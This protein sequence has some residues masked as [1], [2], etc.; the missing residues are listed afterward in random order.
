MKIT[1]E[2]LKKIIVKESKLCEQVYEIEKLVGERLYDAILEGINSSVLSFTK[3]DEPLEE[4]VSDYIYGEETRALDSLL[5]DGDFYKFISGKMQEKTT[6]FIEQNKEKI[7]NKY[8]E[9]TKEQQE[10]VAVAK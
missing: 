9:W 10:D 7:M 2:Q 5:D 1:K 4:F 3:E 6:S 8:D